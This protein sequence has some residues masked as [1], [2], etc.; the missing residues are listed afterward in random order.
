VKQRDPAFAA[1]LAQRTMLGRTGKA[2][3]I[4]GPVL[5]LASPASSFV[6]GAVLAADG[7]WTAW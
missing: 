1:R 5:F 7:G 3:E 2:S 6:T 4:R